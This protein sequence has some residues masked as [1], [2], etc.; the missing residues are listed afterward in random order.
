MILWTR[1]PFGEGRKRET[2]HVEVA[3]DD[4][5][6]RVIASA[7]A[8]I[9]GESDWT[10]RVL[11]GGLKPDDAQTVPLHEE[12]HESS[13]AAATAIQ[14]NVSNGQKV[15]VAL[16][17]NPT[18]SNLTNPAGGGGGGGG[19]ASGFGSG[20]AAAIQSAF[21]QS[22]LPAAGWTIAFV[23]DATGATNLT[24]YLDGT[25]TP[26]E[27][28]SG[29]AIPGGV[30]LGQ[31]G[32][33]FLPSYTHTAGDLTAAELTALDGLGPQIEGY[34]NGGGGFYS[35]TETPEGGAAAAAAAPAPRR[36]TAG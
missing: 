19:G 10:C 22:P 11:V 30:S 28:L 33:L 8:G 3:E 29:A 17:V 4:A 27:T 26:A 13:A 21:N 23:Y 24:S 34:V 31:T 25:T 7:E 9:S 1:R 5:F 32:L 15:L 36:L 14:P 6:K 35:Q 16:G 20:A 18:L 2:L 12:D